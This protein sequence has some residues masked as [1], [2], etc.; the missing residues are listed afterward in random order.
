MSCFDRYFSMF[1]VEVEAN[2]CL[3]SD[4][5]H[6]ITFQAEGYANDKTMVNI[7]TVC[8][9]DCINDEKKNKKFSACNGNGKY[10][11]VLHI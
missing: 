11:V 7:A 2:E 6:Q 1:E 3:P 8:E 5:S 4:R 10:R 9:C